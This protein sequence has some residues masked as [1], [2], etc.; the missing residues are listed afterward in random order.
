MTHKVKIVTGYSN[1][2]GSTV[3]FLR[4]TNLFN[5]KGYDCTLYGP[6]EWH[7][8]QCKGDVIPNFTIDGETTLI[9]HFVSIS[10]DMLCKKHILA[11]HETGVFNMRR[12][13]ENEVDLKNYD[14]IVFVSKSQQEWQENPEGSIV[15]P[16][17][18]CDIVPTKSKFNPKVAAV[19]G[20]IDAHKQTHISIER[21]LK[22]GFEHI[23]IFGD[24]TDPDYFRAKIQPHLS[25]NVRYVGFCDNKQAMYEGLTAVYHSSLR[26]TYNFVQFEC[27]LAGVK[28]YPLESTMNDAEMWSE[29]RIFEAWDKI[30]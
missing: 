10:R 16:N 29:D 4:L 12:G 5:K 3:A 6:H 13:V 15:I 20:S 2:G 11:C 22:D 24:V 14:N 28:Y 23:D 7:L 8:K 17:I 19:I 1:P 9:S 18:V 27:E 26:E 21:A 25:R 30:L